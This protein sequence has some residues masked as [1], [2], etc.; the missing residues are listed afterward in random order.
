MRKFGI[1]RNK[2]TDSDLGDSYAF[3]YIVHSMSEF[4]YDFRVHMNCST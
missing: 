2:A 4:Q 3:M 1:L